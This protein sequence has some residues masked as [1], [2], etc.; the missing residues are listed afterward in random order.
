MTKT[1]A[2]LFCALAFFLV[3][4]SGGVLSDSEEPATIEQMY[5][6]AKKE[7]AD[8]SVIDALSDGYVSLEE[9]NTGVDVTVKCVEDK[10]YA[11]KVDS[12]PNP[13]DGYRKGFQIVSFADGS[14]LPENDKAATDIFECSK[15][16]ASFLEMGY[17]IT[18]EAVMDPALMAAVQECLRG[19]GQEVT[20]EE[21]NMKDLVT[22]GYDDPKWGVVSECVGTRGTEM[23]PDV[24]IT[25]TG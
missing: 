12:M 24:D 16:F 15:R 8:Q 19:K 2:A 11:V 10:G 9:Y 21:K 7:K 20:G 1:V 17:E 23:Y 3:G 13:V 6:D 25:V 14:S 22:D 18:N 5:K 4:C